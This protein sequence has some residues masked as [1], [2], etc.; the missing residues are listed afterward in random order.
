M[1]YALA[2]QRPLRALA[3]VRVAAQD[4][5][6]HLDV[7]LEEAL[8]RVREVGGDTLV[9]RELSTSTRLVNGA[10]MRTCGRFDGP[11]SGMPGM[12]CQ[13]PTQALEVEL[14]LVGTAMRRTRAPSG[15]SPWGLPPPLGAMPQSESPDGGAPPSEPDLSVEEP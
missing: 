10:L 9:I 8:D 14:T 3:E 6:A 15:D 5:R 2:P 1:F 12:P 11:I 13:P 7:V 4:E